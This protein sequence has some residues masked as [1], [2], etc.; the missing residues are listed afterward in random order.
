MLMPW[1]IVP[2]RRYMMSFS[3]RN[4]RQ[5]W[6]FGLK[7]FATWRNDIDPLALQYR[8]TNATFGAAAAVRWSTAVFVLQG[9]LQDVGLQR[10]IEESSAAVPA[11]APASDQPDAR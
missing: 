10:M 3:R 8:S 1:V 2:P 6:L 4:N 11:Q 5:I 7:H 9:Q